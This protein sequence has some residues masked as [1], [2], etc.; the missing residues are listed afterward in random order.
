MNDHTFYIQAIFS[1]HVQGVGFRYSTLS[2]VKKYKISGFVKN[3]SDGTVELQAEG[4]ET[5]VL[6]FLNDLQDFMS[7]Y[8]QDTKLSRGSRPSQFQSFD[9][10]Y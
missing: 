1:G 5:E 9:I 6:K 10:T 8:I 3:L 4:Q 2:V 7:S